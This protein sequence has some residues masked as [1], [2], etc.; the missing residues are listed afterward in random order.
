MPLALVPG[1]AAQRHALVQ[2]AVVADFGSFANHHAHAVVDEDAPAQRGAGVDFNAG[3]TARQLRGEPSQPFEATAPKPV[4]QPMHQHSMKARVEGDH[5][6][7]TAHSR[8]AFKNDVDLLANSVQ[9][10]E[11]LSK[12]AR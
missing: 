5:L 3:E 6:P 11:S 1:G 7:A 10:Q 8:I 4:G 9:H 12:W 2:G